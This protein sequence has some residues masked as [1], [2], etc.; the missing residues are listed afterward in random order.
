MTRGGMG[1]DILQPMLLASTGEKF[2]CSI[3]EFRQAVKNSERKE[4]NE[5]TIVPNSD[6][7][8]GDVTNFFKSMQ[9][10]RLFLPSFP[11]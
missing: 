4:N 10:Y 8:E 6:E 2:S 11:S 1:A 7:P 9:W 5:E 3:A